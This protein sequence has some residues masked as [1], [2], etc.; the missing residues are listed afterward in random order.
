MKQGRLEPL[1]DIAVAG[2]LF[3]LA[4]LERCETVTRQKNG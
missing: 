1:D 4:K 3:N 2:A